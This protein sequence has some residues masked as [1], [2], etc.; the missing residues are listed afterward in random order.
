MNYDQIKGHLL[1]GT[2]PL[3]FQSAAEIFK[4]IVHLKL[5]KGLHTIIFQLECI[6]PHNNHIWDFKPMRF[7]N[8]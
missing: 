8:G 6:M 2:E 7:H 1:S 3:N 4:G 5:V